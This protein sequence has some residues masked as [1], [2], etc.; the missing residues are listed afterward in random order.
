ME[1][2]IIVEKTTLSTNIIRAGF[3]KAHMNP[4]TERL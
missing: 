4:S 1:N 2:R 3:S